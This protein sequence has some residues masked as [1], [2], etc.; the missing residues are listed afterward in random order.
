MQFC[1][2]SFRLVNTY[3][4]FKISYIF[5]AIDNHANR[6]VYAYLLM[7]KLFDMYNKFDLTLMK[8]ISNG[9]A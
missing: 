2:P 3:L 7:H 8:Q 9:Y 1:H 4:W 6:E 5:L